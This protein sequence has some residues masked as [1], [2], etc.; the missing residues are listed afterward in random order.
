MENLD[1]DIGNYTIKDIEKF[2]RFKPRSKYTASDIELREYEIREQ[3][4]NS[5]HINKRFKRDLIE[6]LSLAKDWLIYVKCKPD[7]KQPTTIPKNYKLDTLD[8][9]VSAEI[10][11][12][13]GELT[14]RPDTQYINTQ[15]SDFF[16]GIMNPL[17]TRVITKCLNIDTRFRDNIY[18]TKCTDFTINLPMKFSKVVSMQLA[19]LEFPVTF[20]GISEELGNNFIY[21]QVN[22]NALDGSE[23][24]LDASATYYIPD[25]NY[26]S[27][28]VIELLNAQLCPLDSNNNMTQPDNIFSYVQMVIDV[29][30]NGS[31][32]G[33]VT[34]Y[35]TGDK[36]SNINLITL[37]FTRGKNGEVDNVPLTNKLG[38]NL[39]FQK[40]LYNDATSYTADTIVEPSNVRYV[41][42]IVDDFN[43]SA[44]NHFIS[45][46]NKSVLNPNIL[47]R[48][49]IKGSYFSIIMGNDFNITSEPRKYFGPV[50]I[51]RLKIQIVDE[52]GK[53]LNMNNS[54]FSFC[55][56][57]KMLYDL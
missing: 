27:S 16:P 39:G 26:N 48:I 10:P 21:I 19:A 36:A 56:N 24:V 7:E 45:V 15:N 17:S 4:L 5:G 28:D 52:Y 25:G 9:P 8:T 3:L 40:T 20:Y 2:F 50:D 32:S 53:I 30:A 22:Y 41:Y 51:Q 6:F 29:T 1:L 23:E 47:A 42:L 55:L 31:G 43:K 33:K 46:F 57:L 49:A 13:N 12:R 34:I 35:P 38:W 14:I 54:N 44:N 37:D 11:N 18:T